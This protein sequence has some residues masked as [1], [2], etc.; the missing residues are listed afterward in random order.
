M[1][2]LLLLTLALLCFGALANAD[3][4][5]TYATR[6]QQNP[7]DFID[8]TQ[9]GPDFTIS[10]TTIPS[11][12][13]VSTFNGNLATVGN[14]TGGDF[15]R[16]DQGLGWGGSFDNGEALIWTGNPNFGLGGFG[17]FSVALQQPV[18]SVGF[19]IEADEIAPFTATTWA[20]DTNGNLLFTYTINGNPNCGYGAGCEAFVGI[21]DLS[22]PNIASVVISTDSGDPFWNNDFAIDAISTSALATP[23]PGSI[24]L[25][26]S[27][28]IGIA[29]VL[30]RKLAR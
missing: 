13:V 10:G 3:S 6:A 15:L 28:L 14:I 1:R 20:Y 29:G 12:Q 5:T 26:G 22:G 9:L 27:G 19:G 18:A 4:F 23:E 24:A 8:W 25:L 21:G 17:P 2:K 7:D 30:R 11:P 16:V